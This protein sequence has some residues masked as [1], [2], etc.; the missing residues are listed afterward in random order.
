[1]ELTGNIGGCAGSVGDKM[2]VDVL[3]LKFMGNF[4]IKIFLFH[5]FCSLAMSTIL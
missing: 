3:N 2:D 4:F 1:M 5:S